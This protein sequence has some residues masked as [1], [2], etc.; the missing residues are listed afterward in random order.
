MDPSPPPP[1]PRRTRHWAL[2]VGVALLAYLLVAYLLLPM[3][4]LHYARRHPE[5]VDAPRITQTV[6]HIPGDPLNVCLIGSKE[7]LLRILKAAGWHAADPLSLRSD[8]KIAEATVL[9]RPY[10]D[11]PVSNL[12]LW[13]RREDL[14]FEQPVGDNPRQRHH[15]RFWKSETPAADGRPA[16]FGS[17]TFD[18]R[19][20]FS[21]T[22][23]QITH[24]VAAD[25]DTERDH[26]MGSLQKTG[27]L[28]SREVEADFHTVHEGRNGGG[29]PWRTDGALAIGTI[30]AE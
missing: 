9:E 14:A 16:W 11:A 30:K 23:G 10:A 2:G 12:Y 18:E 24:H 25:I 27:E 22:T 7:D 19:V 4:W 6:D 5:L 26:L 20:G 8:L 15:V 3:D 17:A 13:G 1:S 29:D 28:T 21:H